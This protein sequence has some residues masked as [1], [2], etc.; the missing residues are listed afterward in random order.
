MKIYVQGIYQNTLKIIY[1]S[2]YLEVYDVKFNTIHAWL[3]SYRLINSNLVY[4]FFHLF[5]SISS[6]IQKRVTW[7]KNSRFREICRIFDKS[8]IV[9]EKKIND[10]KRKVKWESFKLAFEQLLMFLKF[11]YMQK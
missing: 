11:H 1:Q 2:F 6:D 10:P 4:S 7:K 8:I 3:E 5:L 9:Q